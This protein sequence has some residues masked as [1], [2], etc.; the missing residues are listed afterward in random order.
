MVP[1]TQMSKVDYKCEK[2]KDQG[3][4]YEKREGVRFVDKQGKA[5]TMMTD[6]WIICSCEKEQRATQLVTSSAITPGF[7]KKGFKNFQREGVDQEVQRMF[8]EAVK[9]YEH[10]DK[11]GE[12]LLFLGQPGTGKTHLMCAIANGLMREHLLP[13]MYFPWVE[14]MSEVSANQFEHKAAITARMKNV[15]VLFIDDL[16]KPTQGKSQA[17]PW[18]S[19]MLYE[20]VNH[21]YLNSKPIMV[22]SELSVNTLFQTDEATVS[23]LIEMAGQH[24]VQLSSNLQNNYRL[25]GVMG[26]TT[27]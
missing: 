3:G 25:R 21:R 7:Q 24:I 12:S 23:R 8:M 2:C 18:Q 22:S 4:T 16:Y 5:K 17:F 9:Y 11:Q 20:V 27:Q 10:F 14:G 1:S 13:V 15:E 6:V 26:G 19:T